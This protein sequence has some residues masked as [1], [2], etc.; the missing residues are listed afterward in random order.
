MTTSLNF[1]QKGSMSSRGQIQTC[2]I[3]TKDS[4][5]FE[6]VLGNIG[7]FLFCAQVHAVPREQVLHFIIAVFMFVGNDESCDNSNWKILRSLVSHL[8]Y[9]I[10]YL[11]F[12]DVHPRC[13]QLK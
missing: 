7:A 1:K 9:Y 12:E 2:F 5:F 4:I 6:P 13:E 10:K 8:G 11:Q 3:W